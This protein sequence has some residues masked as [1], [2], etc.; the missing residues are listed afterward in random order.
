MFLVLWMKRSSHMCP[1]ATDPKQV[2]DIVA[3]YVRLFCLFVCLFCLF[4]LFACL[5]VVCLF[6]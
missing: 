1:L 4:C 6:C 3:N 2:A 5:L